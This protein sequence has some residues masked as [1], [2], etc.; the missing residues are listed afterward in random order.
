[1]T[2]GRVS[3]PDHVATGR[4]LDADETRRHH[5]RLCALPVDCPS[6][7][8]IV[9]RLEQHDCP[10]SR[11]YCCAEDSVLKRVALSEDRSG[12]PWGRRRFLVRRWEGRRAREGDT[13]IDP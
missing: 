1:M 11:F 9:G 2:V 13:G 12:R 6:T 3:E 8:W 7:A 5:L 4:D 10:T